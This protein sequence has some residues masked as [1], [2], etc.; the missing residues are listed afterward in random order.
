MRLTPLD[1]KQKRFQT[2]FRGC[3]TEEVEEFL[4]LLSEQ[5]EE[6]QREINDLKDQLARAEKSL[7]EF[8]EREKS[9][10]ETLVAA[11]RMAE[12]V[13]GVAEREARVILSNAELE[14][15]RLVQDAVRRRERIVS[16]IHDL[17]RQKIQFETT[18]KGA[19]EVHLKMMEALREHEEK[20]ETENLEFLRRKTPQEMPDPLADDENSE[21]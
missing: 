8:A 13:R 12:E 15:E 14:G 3:R 17:K 11:Q 10:Q 7:G 1:I 2:A 5:A 19:I 9:L 6:M 4:V 16:E 20:L 18:L 21:T